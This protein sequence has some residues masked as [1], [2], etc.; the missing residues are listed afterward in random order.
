MMVL[1]TAL[2]ANRGTVLTLIGAF[3]VVD[4]P[5]QTA[6]A[7]VVLAGG[8]P[9]REMEAAAVYRDG[10]SSRVL[11]V[12]DGGAD[13]R[14]SVL[15]SLGIP[16]SSIA[17]ILG[18]ASDTLSELQLVESAMGTDPGPVILVTSKYHS[19]RVRAAWLQASAGRQSP[20]VRGVQYDAFNP[21]GWW[22]DSQMARTVVHEYLGLIKLAL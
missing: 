9:Q 4:D 3:L 19:R 11:L 12:A 13:E 18:R 8:T 7:I 16:A 20:V 10:W 1:A 5:L 15:L 6:S 22:R 2:I 14:R 17:V 21:S